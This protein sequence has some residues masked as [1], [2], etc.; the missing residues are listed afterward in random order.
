MGRL[1]QERLK[2]HW[3]FLRAAPLQNESA[4]ESMLSGYETCYK[5]AKGSVRKTTRNVSETFEA[6][7]LLLKNILRALL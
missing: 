1:V 2:C 4:S 3:L 7:R 6:P 5:N